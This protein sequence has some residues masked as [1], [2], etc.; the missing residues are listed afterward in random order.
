[1]KKKSEKMHTYINLIS[2]NDALTK[3]NS[4]ELDVTVKELSLKA[5]R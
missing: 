3:N 2:I 1:M 5:W 4:S